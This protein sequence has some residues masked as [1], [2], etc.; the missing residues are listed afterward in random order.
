[1]NSKPV[2]K[3][4]LVIMFPLT[5]TLALVKALW[6]VATA[7]AAVVGLLLGQ[8]VRLLMVVAYYV[9]F[10][11]LQGWLEGRSM[12]MRGQQAV[13]RARKADRAAKA[14]KAGE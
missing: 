13:E 4:A 11:G 10:Y 2:S 5:A 12:V 7:F 1:M 14:P 9:F 3:I 8:P 6:V